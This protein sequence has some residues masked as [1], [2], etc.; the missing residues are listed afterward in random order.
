MSHAYCYVSRNEPSFGGCTLADSWH[1][2]MVGSY[3]AQSFPWY[4]GWVSLKGMGVLA[5]SLPSPLF[6]GKVIVS[7]NIQTGL[8]GGVKW[9]N[10]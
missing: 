3:G 4:W 1:L 6:L 8:F 7:R 2:T 9:G 10:Y 5:V